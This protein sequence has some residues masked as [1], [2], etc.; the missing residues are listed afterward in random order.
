[1][2]V[3]SLSRLIC[4]LVF[5]LNMATKTKEI[6]K[7]VIFISKKINV[8]TEC[9]KNNKKGKHIRRFPVSSLKRPVMVVILTILVSITAMW[10][11]GFVPVIFMPD[12]ERPVVTANIELPLGTDEVVTRIEEFIEDSLVVNG[13]RTKGVVDW[14]VY[15]G[16]GAPK[17]DLGYTPPETSP[18]AAHVFMNTTSG[19][20]NQYVIDILDAFCFEN[21]PDADVNVSKLLSG[22]GSANPIEVRIA[23]PDEDMLYKLSD[24][25]KSILNS[26]QGAKSIDDSW[27]LPTKKFVV[28]IN[29]A[30]AKLA[31]IFSQDIAASLQATLTG[32]NVGQ[33]RE[34]DKVIP[35][36]MRNAPED[37]NNL[38][39]L[40]SVNIYAQA[41]GANVPL[42]QVADI[43]LVWQASKILRRDL[44]RTI[45]VTSDIQNGYTANE[46][47]TRLKPLLDN[48]GNS[49]PMGYSFELGGEDE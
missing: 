11:M 23:G 43:D 46:V 27:G 47:T 39:S 26:L 30:K 21:F 25:V 32:A 38:E 36:V 24:S 3:K 15:I 31:G 6:N 20:D 42:K 22:G 29:Q 2:P 37:L 10:G 33:F 5:K 41:T 16:E 35:I 7:C 40:E 8:L 1:M 45:T 44:N 49:W 48:Y 19:D 18:N 28:H 9:G 17:Y 13:K 14:S 4:D 34:E 12:S